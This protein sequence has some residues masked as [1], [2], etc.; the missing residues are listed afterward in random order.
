MRYADG[1]AG[2]AVKSIVVHRKRHMFEGRCDIE[3]KIPRLIECLTQAELIR[4]SNST[5]SGLCYDSRKIRPGDLFFAL[6]GIHVDGRSFIHKAVSSGAAAVV[7]DESPG[8]SVSTDDVP[9]GVALIR[10]PDARKAMAP[11]AAAFYNYPAEKLVITGV[12][13]TD[14]KSTTVYL[15]HQLLESAG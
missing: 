8:L 13:G 10:V 2:H 15:I 11:L 5:V 3:T 6:P 9:P 14:G 1:C 4:H 7:F 12:T